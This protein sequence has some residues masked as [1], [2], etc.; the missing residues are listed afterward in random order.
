MR[1]TKIFSITYEGRDELEYSTGILVGDERR[2]MR[3][4]DGISSVEG[5]G[6]KVPP[7]VRVN[8]DDIFEKLL[9]ARL[10]EDTGKGAFDIPLKKLAQMFEEKV[11]A[12]ILASKEAHKD[13]VSFAEL[14]LERR[15]EAEHKLASSEAKL[16]QT[17]MSLAL[18]TNQYESLQQQV[19]T[20]KQ[21]MEARIG[22]QQAQLVAVL[23]QSKEAQSQ[24]FKLESELNQMRSDFV[25][26]QDTI[27]KKAARMDETLRLRVLE[28]QHA[29]QVKKEQMKVAADEMVRSHPHYARIRGL[30]FFK[31]FRNSDL[32]ELLLWTE[33]KEF[34][35]D[36]QILVEGEMSFPFY[37][38]VSGKLQVLKGGK[39]LI[40]LKAGEPF[41]EISYLDN[42]NPHRSASVAAKTDCELLLLD[43]SYLDNAAPMLRMCIA[44]AIVRVQAKRL[45]RAV[46]MVVKLLVDKNAD[47]EL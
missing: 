40:V 42:D 2:V 27:E 46:N 33:W 37:I 36:T 7:S 28:E 24:R 9:A 11:E 10:I 21:G 18:I 35:E 34:K 26:M 22:E 31:D 45:R 13:V 17:N 6:K 38:I 29:L 12:A 4:I 15:V 41:G 44:E 43:P 32:A 14:E 3:L 47:V 19:A 25:Q 1:Q 20:Y 8:L 5:I 30:E 23:G 39:E 16:T